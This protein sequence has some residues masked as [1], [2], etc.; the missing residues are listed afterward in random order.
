MSCKC[1][2]H[3]DHD[4][5]REEERCEHEESADLLFPKTN[6]YHCFDFRTCESRCVLC[7]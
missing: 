3:D 6:I 5:H 7:H 4:E 1:H 2:D